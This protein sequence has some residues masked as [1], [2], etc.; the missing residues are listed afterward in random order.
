MNIPFQRR[1][2]SV[3]TR[4]S[5]QAPSAAKDCAFATGLTPLPSDAVDEVVHALD[6]HAKRGKVDGR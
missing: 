5:F 3:D 2:V 6:A 1:A 4:A